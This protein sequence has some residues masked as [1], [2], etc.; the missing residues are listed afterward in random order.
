MQCY[1]VNCVLEG[2]V[3]RR[4]SFRGSSKFQFVRRHASQVLTSGRAVLGSRSRDSKAPEGKQRGAVK[5]A[6][7][8]TGALNGR[9]NRNPP[10]FH[11]NIPPKSSVSGQNIC[12][13]R[14]IPINPSRGASRSQVSGAAAGSIW[15]TKDSKRQRWDDRVMQLSCHI[16][17]LSPPRS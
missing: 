1:G 7:K 4:R 12:R 5:E 11:L 16:I 2:I 14:F 3:L 9:T 10:N 13:R 6:S 15:R 17:V 8:N